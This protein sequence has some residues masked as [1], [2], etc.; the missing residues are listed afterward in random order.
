MCGWNRKGVSQLL[1]ATLPAVNSSLL[2]GA[3]RSPPIKFHMK[4]SLLMKDT[5]QAQLVT[6]PDMRFY[7]L[8]RLPTTLCRL[9]LIA[10][11]VTTLAAVIIKARSAAL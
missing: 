8:K 3:G 10:G 9:L 7:K 5:G 2:V 6:L 11:R 1:S 4:S